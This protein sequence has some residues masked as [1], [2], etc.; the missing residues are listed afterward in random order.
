MKKALERWNNRI[1][2]NKTPPQNSIL[3]QINQVFQESNVLE[4]SG[5]PETDWV[6]VRNLLDK[7]DCKRLKS[8]VD[9]VRNVRLLKR[10]TQLRSEL[11]QTWRTFSNYRHALQLTRKVFVQARFYSSNDEETGVILM[12]M[13]KAKGKQFDEVIILDGWPSHNGITIFANP[14]RIVQNN[15]LTKKNSTTSRQ[16]L[17]VSV[18]RAKQMTTLLTPQ[19]DECAL[20]KPYF[21]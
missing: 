15:S 1:Q 14:N 20:L 10:G 4:Y 16:N 5:N 12:N 18:T 19:R 9:E 7:R 21:E 11:A 8:V 13:H 17:M 3:S 2:K 6:Q